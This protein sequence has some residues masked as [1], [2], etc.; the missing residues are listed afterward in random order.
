M[1]SP[2]ETS[3]DAVPAGTVATAPGPVLPEPGERLSVRREDRLEVYGSGAF[4]GGGEP[5]HRV[6]VPAET[7]AAPL[8]D[9]AVLAEPD[10]VRAVGGDGAT[11]WELPHP[12]WRGGLGTPRAPGVPSVS[13]DGALVGVV[14]PALAEEPGHQVLFRDE[15]TR[16]RYGRDVLLLVEA[17]N[18]RIRASRPVNSCASVV[19]QRWHPGGRLLALSCWTAWYSWSTWW[20]AP[21]RDGL[22]LRGSARMREVVGF[23]PG[24][25]R[26]LTLRRAERL[27]PGDDRDELA[28]HTIGTDEPVALYDLAA[29]TGPEPDPGEGA[30]ERESE[31]VFEDAHLLDARHVLVTARHQPPGRRPSPRHWLCDTAT[32]RPLGRMRY[33]EPPG[34][35]TPLGDGTWLTEGVRGF[36]RWSLPAG[37]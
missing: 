23:V 25:F 29:L 30:D 10:R 2:A 15:R 37:G 18:G 6:E 19:T 8:D 35:V 14:V 12:P 24:S 28:A 9:G 32:L 3:I 1:T 33:P 34:P 7:P 36:H 5:L 27:A 4:L 21:R 22:H 17:A 20:V 31:A 13:P 16:L 26:A 11:R